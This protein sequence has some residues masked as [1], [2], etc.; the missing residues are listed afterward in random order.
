MLYLKKT[1]KSR[2]TP[3]MSF[4]YIKTFFTGNQQHLSYQ[5]IQI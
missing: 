5:Q 3:H 2:E 1:K 4:T